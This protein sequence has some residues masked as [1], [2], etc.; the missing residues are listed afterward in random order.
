MSVKKNTYILYA[1]KNATVNYLSSNKLI[2]FKTALLKVFNAM[3]TCFDYFPLIR[4]GK[5]K[6]ELEKLF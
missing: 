4:K 1:V 6:K 2:N 5:Q 3:V